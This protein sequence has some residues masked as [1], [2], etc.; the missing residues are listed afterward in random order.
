M[1]FQDIMESLSF[2]VFQ[3]HERPM[4]GVLVKVKKVHNVCVLKTLQK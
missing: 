1:T 4:Q 3:S 2:Q